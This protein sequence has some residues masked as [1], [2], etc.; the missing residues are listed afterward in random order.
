MKWRKPLISLMML[1]FA[2]ALYQVVFQPLWNSWLESM[3]RSVGIAE[4]ATG[5]FLTGLFTMLV[6]RM[7]TRRMD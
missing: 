3:G 5:F 2:L 1:S 7:V 6:T 4:V